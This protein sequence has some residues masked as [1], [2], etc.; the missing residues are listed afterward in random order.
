MAVS[1]DPRVRGAQAERAAER[2]LRLR[3]WRICARNWSGGGGELDIVASRWRTLLVVE[4]RLRADHELA[5]WSID[6]AKLE[7]TRRAA[8]TLIR[9]HGLYRYRL[10][11]DLFLYDHA[12]RLERRSDLD[13]VV[14]D[15][16]RHVAS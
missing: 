1:S 6:A 16:A 8:R 4:V 9:Q 2:H 14:H 7:R 10:R 3:G 5:G 12:G 11:L 13:R 15:P